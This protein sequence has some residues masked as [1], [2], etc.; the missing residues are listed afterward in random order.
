ME[1]QRVLFID[2][3]TSETL[4]L[5]LKTPDGAEVQE[6]KTDHREMLTAIAE[7][8]TS[9]DTAPEQLSAIGVVV[10]EGR[11]TS[12]RITATIANTFR[13]V[14][15]IP[16]FGVEKQLVDAVI[17]GEDIKIPADVGY[18]SPAYSAAPHIGKPKKV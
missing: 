5:V 9:L 13:F 3:S 16:V 15:R 12:T 6:M 14:L 8:L 18:L 11:F 2:P 10:G 1:S 4:R 7:V 17:S